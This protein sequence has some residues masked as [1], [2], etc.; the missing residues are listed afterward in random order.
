MFCPGKFEDVF[1]CLKKRYHY[2]YYEYST[3]NSLSFGKCTKEH[4]DNVKKDAKYGIYVVRK[5]GCNNVLYIGMAGTI[6]NNGNFKGQDI[7]KRLKAMRKSGMKADEYFEKL[8]EREGNLFIE[9]IILPKNGPLSPALVEA[10]LLQA[11]LNE[12]RKLPLEN[13]KL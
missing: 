4:F 5:R 1:K 7:P 2:G 10:I 9:Y 6:D 3:S 8:Y 13:N 11:Y 12:N